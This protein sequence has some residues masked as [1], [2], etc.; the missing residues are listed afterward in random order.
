[1]TLEA[2]TVR[3]D[4]L[5]LSSAVYEE[6]KKCFSLELFEDLLKI[7][8]GEDGVSLDVFA[9]KYAQDDEPTNP[10]RDEQVSTTDRQSKDT[11]END[12]T[13]GSKSVDLL[14]FVYE[15]V[16]LTKVD[17]IT[18]EKKELDPS[19]S[20]EVNK[21]VIHPKSESPTYFYCFKKQESTWNLT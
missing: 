2:L 15:Y 1:M 21:A 12:L 14:E 10:D 17:S 18:W 19:D 7:F 11:A 6:K 13:L 5:N 8:S 9:N 4:S 20:F 3:R 16:N